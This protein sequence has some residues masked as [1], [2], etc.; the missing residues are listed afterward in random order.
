[1]GRDQLGG[2]LV[3]NLADMNRFAAQSHRLLDKVA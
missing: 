3:Q 2:Y 1:V